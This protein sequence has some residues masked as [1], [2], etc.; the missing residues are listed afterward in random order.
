MEKIVLVFTIVTLILISIQVI[1]NIIA[2]IMREK[3][4]RKLRSE[5]LYGKRKIIKKNK[6]TNGTDD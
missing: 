5:E 4:F 3:Y 1:L 6:R 2:D